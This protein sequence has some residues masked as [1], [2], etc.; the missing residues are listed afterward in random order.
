MARTSR[1]NPTATLELGA[2]RPR[3]S[4]AAYIRLSV[5]DNKKKGDSVETQ[6]SIL[7]DFIA[8]NPELHLYDYYIDNG[9]T[10]MNFSRPAFQKMLSDAENGVINCII[11][12]DLSRFGRNVIDTGYYIEKY[13]PVLKVRFVAVNDNFDNSVVNPGDSIMLP[14][15][16]MINEAYALDIERKI[17]AQQRQAMHNGDFI[18]ARSPYGYLKH[19]ENCHKLVVDPQTAPVVR[20]IF[21][22]AYEKAGINDIARR[23]NEAGIATPSHTKKASGHI[24]HENLLGNNKWQTH[25]VALILSNEVYTGDMVQ[26]KS[27]TTAHNQMRSEEIIRKICPPRD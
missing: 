1:K 5:E 15:K 21:E 26:G 8:M 13:L 22:W 7:D 16:N 2:I 9:T 12:K 25:T 17:K 23:L 6:K 24:K 10:G 18:G 11:V 20:Q 3:Y 27:K 19:P 14:L 4:V